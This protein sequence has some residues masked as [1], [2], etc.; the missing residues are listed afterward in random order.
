VRRGCR[1]F[2]R[3][4]FA[5]RTLTSHSAESDALPPSF[6]I[7][8]AVDDFFLH[9]HNQPYSFFN[10]LNFRIRL[11]EGLLPDYLIFAV[12]ATAARFSTTNVN[13]AATGHAGAQSSW[14]LISK[15]M[16]TDEES[17]ISIVQA[18]TLLAIFDFTGI[19]KSSIERFAKTLTW[20]P[21]L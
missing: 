19:L 4:C 20:R 12:L 6:H 13:K 5:F 2:L 15:H 7:Q 9:S 8:S 18:A 1:K 10:E 21:S 11:A 14:K 16:E 17:D 3:L